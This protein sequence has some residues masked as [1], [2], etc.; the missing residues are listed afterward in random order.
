MNV[1][2]GLT[3]KVRRNEDVMDA[4][5]R[6]R[7]KCERDGL[8]N[9]IKKHRYFEKPSEKKRRRKLAAL[10]RAAKKARGRNRGRGKK[11][12]GTARRK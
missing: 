1:K 5:K 10:K 8:F 3:V 12:K 7:K 2:P 11:G 6:L 9:E 4:Y